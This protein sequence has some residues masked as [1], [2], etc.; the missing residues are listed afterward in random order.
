MNCPPN[1]ASCREKKDNNGKPTF[2]GIGNIA[3][4]VLKMEGSGLT[5][6]YVGDSCPGVSGKQSKLAKC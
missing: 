4:K 3:A 6:E 1:A 2:A 5:I